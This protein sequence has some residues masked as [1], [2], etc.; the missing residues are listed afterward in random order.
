L[1]P[2][3]RGSVTLASSD[4]FDPPIIDINFNATE[5]D[6]YILREGLKKTVSVMS[7]EGVR[8]TNEVRKG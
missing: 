5:A 8:V 6:R 1:T 4:S 7:D 2:A 3:S